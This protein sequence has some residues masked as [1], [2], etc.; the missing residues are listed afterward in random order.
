[1]KMLKEKNAVQRMAKGFT[2]IELLV[3]IAI[4]A[5]LAAIL[6]PV[7]ARARENARRASCQ[8]NLKQI[9]LGL[10][11]YT[12]D[13]DEKLP[14]HRIGGVNWPSLV[15]PYVKS[16]QLFKCPSNT[17]DPT[18]Q[19]MNFS[20]PGTSIPRSYLANG[21]PSAGWVFGTNFESPMTEDAGT[22]LASIQ[23]TSRVVIIGEHENRDQPNYWYGAGD[24][25]FTNHLGVSNF[26]FVDGH[27]KAM[28]PATTVTPVN[29]W[30]NQNR[31]NTSANWTTF[32][33][34]V[35]ARTAAMQ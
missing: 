22:A 32:V 23:E 31:A 16:V 18:T 13:Y 24:V 17:T 25:L 29:M 14:G 19:T 33:N 4:I 26:L 2:P 11:Q 5:I 30:D 10:L 7:F 20:A 15:Q 34:N 3:V 9:G 21:F 27:V 8:S 28:K 12:Q 35:V 1:M 6:F